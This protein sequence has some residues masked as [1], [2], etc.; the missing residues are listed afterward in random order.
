MSWI[1]V[2]FLLA[3]SGGLSFIGILAFA[4]PEGRGEKTA[5]LCFI[6]ATVVVVLAVLLAV[7]QATFRWL[8]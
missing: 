7:V 2:V 3:L 4:D 1:W 6:S 5:L 8:A